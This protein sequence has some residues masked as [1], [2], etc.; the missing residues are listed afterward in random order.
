MKAN[1]NLGKYYGTE[2]QIHWT[3]FLLIAWIVFSEILSGSSTDRI[4][5]NLQFILAVMICVLLHELGHLLAA[6][7]FGVKTKKMVLLPIGG[8]STV[9]NTT[10][11]PKV[12]F[13]IT[14]AGP[15]VNIIIAIVLFF[16]IPVRDYISFNLGEYFTALNDFSVRT[17]LF[18]LF[19]V[20]VALAVFNMIP[21]FPLDG[22][23]ILRALLDVKFTRVKATFLATRISNVIAIVLLLIGLLFNPILVFLSLFLLIGSFSENR[24][25]HQMGLL[26]GHQVRE[27]M[28]KNITVFDPEDTMEAIVKVI[29]TGSETN[30]VVVSDKKI[31]GLLYHK[32]I[33]QNSHKRTLLVRDFMTV[34]FK[35]IKAREGLSVAYRLLQDEPHPFLPVTENDEL[36]G[37]I[38]FANLHEFLLMEDKLK[39]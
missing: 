2:V 37:A 8:I 28:L 22:G 31:V 10:E 18:F 30:F 34:D 7:R 26:K 5:F 21:A 20:N 4:L 39:H 33:I 6:K 23:R 9:D 16:V 17:F 3:F 24:I 25:V 13:L 38:N 32:D 14:L 35:T 1:L 11:S 15:L 29:L 19:I 27:A 36:V 12:E